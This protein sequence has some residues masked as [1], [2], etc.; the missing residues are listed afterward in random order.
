MGIEIF[1]RIIIILGTI[2]FV[3]FMFKK[4]SAKRRGHLQSKKQ[5]DGE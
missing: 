3:W 5:E 4:I 2:A 1:G